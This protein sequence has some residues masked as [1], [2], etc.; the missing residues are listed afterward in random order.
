MK[1]KKQTPKKSIPH[2]K[3]KDEQGAGR[4]AA[5]RAGKVPK[6]SALAAAAQVLRET[7][8]EMNCAQMIEAM[9]AKRYWTSPKGKTPGATL[10]A[11]I[12]RH[13]ATMGEEARFQKTGRGAFVVT[14]KA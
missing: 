1:P 3:P 2:A 10:Y 5:K 13:I 14:G 7:R 9:A 8:T 11:A 4:D 6:R 12:V